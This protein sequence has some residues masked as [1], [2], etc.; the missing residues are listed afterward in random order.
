[1]ENVGE[2]NFKLNN[3]LKSVKLFYKLFD[4]PK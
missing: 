3:L 4:R 1:M 2:L